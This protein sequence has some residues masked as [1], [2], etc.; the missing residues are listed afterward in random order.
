MSRIY[1]AVQNIFVRRQPVEPYT[2]VIKAG[3]GGALAIAVLLLL[4]NLS[5]N[6]L[7]MAPFGASCVLLFSLPNSPLSQPVN[8]IGG[9][10]VSVTIGLALHSFLPIEWWSVSLAVG[11]AIAAMAVLRV[12]HPPAGANPLV[13]FFSSPG[14]EYIIFPVAVGS[15]ILVITAA[16]FHRLPPEIIYPLPAKVNENN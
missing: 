14:W 11:L 8:V 6:I 16:L 10:I 1:S 2:S 7:L 5:D 13:V 12:T 3:L 15:I 9:H 4:S